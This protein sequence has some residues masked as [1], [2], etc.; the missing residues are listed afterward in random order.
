MA[1]Y[2]WFFLN[3]WI[4]LYES[5]K[6]QCS[7]YTCK[8]LWL[9]RLSP[10]A[11]KALWISTS[12]MESKISFFFWHSFSKWPFNVSSFVACVATKD[13]TRNFYP[14]ICIFFTVKIFI[15]L[16]RFVARVS[17]SRQLLGIVTKSCW[18]VPHPGQ[19]SSPATVEPIRKVMAPLLIAGVPPR[20][21]DHCQTLW[22]SWIGC[23]ALDVPDINF[24]FKLF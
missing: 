23:S 12:K 3:E 19:V 17:E 18:D 21:W 16:L 24:S 22:C 14:F 4:Y 5:I 8:A 6:S 11:T 1:P 9:K 10:R 13:K 2:K 7:S 20:L 15:P